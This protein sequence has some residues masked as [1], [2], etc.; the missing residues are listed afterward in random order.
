MD[1]TTFKIKFNE[2]YYSRSV[3]NLRPYKSDKIPE[4]DD[5][6]EDDTVNIGDYV[7]VCDDC[8]DTRYASTFHVAKTLQITYEIYKVWYMSTIARRMQTAK[9]KFVYVERTGRLSNRVPT[10]INR[11]NARFTGKLYEENILMSNL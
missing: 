10:H 8:N 2:R 11:L 4:L 9:W 5:M 1:N 7:A 6:E 3:I